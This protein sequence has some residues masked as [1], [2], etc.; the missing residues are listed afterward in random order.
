[1]SG[2]EIILLVGVV[3][4]WLLVVGIVGV[5]LRMRNAL[6]EMEKTLEDVRKELAE[7]SP[8]VQ[9]LLEETSLTT[10]ELRNA[11]GRVGRRAVGAG[12]TEQKGAGVMIGLRLL[13]VAI[14]LAKGIVLPLLKRR[15]RREE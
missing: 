11:I 15:R 9:T 6:G 7:V 8:R 1:M 5:G 3:G 12:G 10:A 2:V 4:V 13:P 14:G